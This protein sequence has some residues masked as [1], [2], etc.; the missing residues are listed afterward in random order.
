VQLI[1]T[2]RE[3]LNVR[4]EHLYSVQGMDYAPSATLESAATSSAVRLFAQSA[5]RAQPAF[6]LDA[7][8]LA[9]VL[10]ICKLVQGMP[11]G[12]EQAAAWIETLPLEEIATEI[13]HSA[14]FLAADWRDAPERQRSMRAVFDWSWRLLNDVERQ[15][16][17]QLAVFR[18]GCTREAAQAVVGAALPVLTSLVHKSLLRWGQAQGG[19]GRYEMHELLRQ[20]AAEQLDGDECTAAEARHSAFYLAFVA[21]RERRMARNEPREA[22]AEIQGEIDNI[23]QAWAWAA[24]QCEIQALDASA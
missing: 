23:R 2:S 19:T 7:S 24:R 12:L 5:R 9:T 22:A 16:L 18:G 3:R 15:V 4:G 17:R 6:S 11:L 10:R 8:N 21:A 14:D 13:E 1:A 20:F